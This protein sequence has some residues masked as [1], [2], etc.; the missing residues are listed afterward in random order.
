M[1]L[2]CVDNIRSELLQITNSFRSWHSAIRS[3]EDCGVINKG[4]IFRQNYKIIGKNRHLKIQS[5]EARL[6]LHHQ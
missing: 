6:Y 2:R 4:T 5:S 3:I 1:R